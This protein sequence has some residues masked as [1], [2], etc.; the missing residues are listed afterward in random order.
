MS[1]QHLA[2]LKQIDNYNDTVFGLV[3]F[4]NECGWSAEAR[5][6]DSGF[7]FGV[8]RKM[9]ALLADETLQRGTITPDLVVQREQE[10][11]IVAEVKHSWSSS[12]DWNENIEQIQKYDQNLIG[13][14]SANERLDKPHDLALLVHGSRSVK[15]SDF[16]TEGIKAGK[17]VFSRQLSVVGYTRADQVQQ[18]IHLRREFGSFSDTKFDERLRTVLPVPMDKVIWKD[19]RFYDSPPPMPYLLQMLWDDVFDA[20]AEG[21]ETVRGRNYVD[22]QV[23]VDG[24]AFQLQNFYGFPA[25]GKRN[26]GI[27]RPQWI[28]D[29]LD[30]FVSFRLARK[31]HD[32]YVIRYRRFRGDKLVRFQRLFLAA[33][34]RLRSRPRGVVRRARRTKVAEGQGRL[35]D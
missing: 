3:A 2:L 21:L 29:A 8:G 30:L 10:Q 28:R 1:A 11:G 19:R 16:L 9:E 4:L 12:A 13:W 31:E 22:L 27:P 35:F 17:F 33:Q 34:T 14:W 32:S 15:V 18:F 26:P 23:Q 20:L 5:N 7:R 24:L 25:D 6:M